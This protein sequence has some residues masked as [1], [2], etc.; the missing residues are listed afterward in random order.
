VNEEIL[1]V[2][3]CAE[4][5]VDDCA[6]VDVIELVAGCAAVDVC[7]LWLATVVEAVAAAHEAIKKI[8]AISSVTRRM[9]LVFF[10]RDLSFL[11]KAFIEHYYM[12]ILLSVKYKFIYVI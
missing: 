1:T 8:E 9:V 12:T 10:I 5:A 3:P 2:L 11:S 4:A 6:P 7:V